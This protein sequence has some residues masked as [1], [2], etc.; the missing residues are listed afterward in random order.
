MPAKIDADAFEHLDEATRARVKSVLFATL[1]GEAGPVGVVEVVN[2]R[3]GD[4]KAEDTHFLEEACRLA[5][6]ALT[7]LGAIES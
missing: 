2:K 5:G 1:P 7:N 3:S 4:F 6:Y